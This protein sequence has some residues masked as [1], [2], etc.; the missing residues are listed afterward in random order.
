MIKT[1]HMNRWVIYLSLC[2]IALSSLA[3]ERSEHWKARNAQF[4]V[5]MDSLGQVD[6]VFLGNSITEGFDLKHYFPGHE[7]ANRG[8][9]AD[10]LDGLLERLDNSAIALQPK[11]LFIMIG[12]NDIGD[13]RDDVYLKRMFTTLIDTLTLELPNTDIYLHSI[14][15]TSSRWKNCPPEQIRRINKFLKLLAREKELSYVD[16]HPLFLNRAGE[17]FNPELTRDGL[18]LNAKGYEIWVEAIKGMLE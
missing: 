14:L 9:V 4:N 15:P 13:R 12:I 2:L 6:N 17:Y 5:E 3:R 16:L 1:I 11:K 8:I 18:H 7:L 10:H